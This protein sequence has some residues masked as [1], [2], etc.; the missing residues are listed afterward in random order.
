M[1]ISV[2][3]DLKSGLKALER[4]LA[5]AVDVN[6]PTYNHNQSLAITR[7]GGSDPCDPC[8]MVVYKGSRSAFFADGAYEAIC[9]TV[10]AGGEFIGYET[11]VLGMRWYEEMETFVRR[12][13]LSQ[14]A[15]EL[16]RLT[17]KKFLHQQV[18][19]DDEMSFHLSGAGYWPNWTAQAILRRI[20]DAGGVEQGDSLA[21]IIKKAV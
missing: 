7:L 19:W 17:P 21:S 12:C 20:V 16:R 8:V 3:V 14:A 15:K 10:E 4:Y 1:K 11:T 5:F 6:G 2:K 18:T 13:S 9:V